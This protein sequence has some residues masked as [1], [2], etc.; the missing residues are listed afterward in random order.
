VDVL[1]LGSL[2]DIRMPLAIA[3]PTA[4]IA[5]RDNVKFGQV[6]L[7]LLAD[8]LG[9]SPQ[10]LVAST[11][12]VVGA[13]AGL[14]PSEASAG[15]A[16]AAAARASAQRPS[17]V[18]V[19]SAGAGVGPPPAGSSPTGSIPRK[20][21]ASEISAGASGQ[22]QGSAPAVNGV[23]AFFVEIDGLLKR[24]SP[25][26]TVAVPKGAKIKMV[27]ILGQV[28]QGTVM[29]LRGFV[30]RPGDATGHD[31]GT[32]C[33]TS[34]DLIPRFA[35]HRGKSILYQLGAEKGPELL[36][37]AYFEFA[38]PRLQSVRL[39]SDGVERTLSLGQRWSLKAGS[40]VTVLD[41]ALAGDLPLDS[42]RYTLGGRPFP[43]SLPQTLTM[44]EIAVS[45]AVFSH[46]EL[47]G[48][49]VLAPAPAN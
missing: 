21:G 18:P 17:S 12:A 31:R 19:A 34:K 46:G 26:E 40:S 1:G 28:P 9:P 39:A 22:E 13:S 44:P 43:S 14:T 27:D 8:N 47:A 33:D 45:L 11:E 20:A 35:I 30:G 23:K 5:R 49:V 24:I 16:L 2:N 3:K 37:A 42:P 32:T 36:A 6:N 15:E 10:L 25:G 48:K 7:E 41:V 29:N 4:R 38:A